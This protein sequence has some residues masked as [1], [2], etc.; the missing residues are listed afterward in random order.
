[1]DGNIACLVTLATVPTMLPDLSNLA[2]NVY[3]LGT[4]QDLQSYATAVSGRLVVGKAFALDGANPRAFATTWQRH[5]PSWS[6]SAL[7]RFRRQPMRWWLAAAR[8]SG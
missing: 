7:D 8:S 6:S 3:D 1:M 2:D 5:C 4:L